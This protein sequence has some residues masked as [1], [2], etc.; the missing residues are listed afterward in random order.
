MQFPHRP[1]LARV[2][3]SHP[4]WLVLWCIVLLNGQQAVAIPPA[5]GSHL[6]H[7]LHRAQL[8][9][10]AAL[11]MPE[12]PSAWPAGLHSNAVQALQAS[13]TQMRV[14]LE[15]RRQDRSVSQ[16]ALADA[17]LYYKGVVWGLRF[18]T[19]LS[20]GDQALIQRAMEL[21]RLRLGEPSRDRIRSGVQSS[22]RT[23]AYVSVVDGSI[24]PYGLVV[25]K[26]YTDTKPIRLDVVLHGSSRPSGLSELRFLSRFDSRDAH[27]KPAPDVDFIE[28]HPLGR[29]ENCYRW[30][31]ETDV[32]EAIEAVCRRYSIDRNRIVLRG[33]SMGA[34]GT[35]HL[36]LKHP[37]EFVALGPYCGYVD[38]HRFSE[39]PVPGFIRVGPLPSHQERSLAMLDSI[40]Y[41]ANVGVVPTIAAIGDQDVFYQA[42][43]LMAQAIAAEGL[44]MN[45]IISAGTGHVIDPATHREQLRQI[46]IHADAGRDP[47][48]KSLR[49][50][51]H[52]LKYNRCHWIE[53]RSQEVPYAR[54]ELGGRVRMDGITEIETPVNVT[55]FAIH[56][57]AIGRD[58]KSILISGQ[59]IPLRQKRRG[60]TVDPSFFVLNSGKWH[61]DSSGDNVEA[62][63][64]LQGPID[65]AF[66][67]PFVCVRGTR[68]AWNPAVVNR[69]EAILR[70]FQQD[71]AKYMRGDLPVVD[72]SQLT[73]NDVRYKNLILFGDPGSNPWIQKALSGLPLNWTRTRIRM[74]GEEWSASGHLPRLATKNPL[75]GGNQNYLVLNSGHTFGETEFAAFNYL[76]FPRL[77]DWAIEEAGDEMPQSGRNEPRIA[78]AGFLG[79]N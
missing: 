23:H 30:A 2:L 7:L 59:S 38:T 31:G 52:S 42:H 1:N 60:S 11:P 48:P 45:Q 9:N 73:E 72:D 78:R 70:Q 46:A 5:Q 26:S 32:F 63:P 56:P 54:S 14:D 75:K 55:R 65:D 35:W 28:L 74:A 43:V 44:D 57:P 37:D 36:G 8:Q 58:T 64:G 19:N 6:P 47:F 34:S 24:Q 20:I 67:A 51:T 61:L 13:L 17:A 66:T 27:S 79:K 12:I 33:M 4:H 18:E 16:D 25:P 69:T 77:G 68:T 76:L 10:P 41:A 50:V 40:R 49:F 22:S 71:W 3:Q 62:P 15:N 53:I 21:G 29:V 39:T